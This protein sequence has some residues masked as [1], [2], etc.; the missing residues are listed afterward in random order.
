VHELTVESATGL[1][2]LVLRRVDPEDNPDATAEIFS[3]RLILSALDDRLFPALLASDPSGIACGFPAS[4]QT[5]LPGRPTLSPLDVDRWIH[6]LAQAVRTVHDAGIDPKILATLPQFHPWLP[7]DPAPPFWSRHP[8]AWSEARLRVSARWPVDRADGSTSPSDT[9]DLT[10]V[11]RDLHPAN[12]LFDNE[13]LSGIVDW[14]N[15]SLGPVEVDISRA[16]VQAAMLVGTEAAEG[17]LRHCAPMC[18]GYDHLWDALVALEIAPWLSDIATTVRAL[19]TAMR[20]ES[21]R[22]SLD[23]IVVASL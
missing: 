15:A 20:V 14:T 17:L 8:S 11:H 13:E 6:G 3:E 5:R 19:G 21:L 1:Q 10:L 4:L 7:E 12:V 18:P 2:R 9:S 23:A 22:R 16:K